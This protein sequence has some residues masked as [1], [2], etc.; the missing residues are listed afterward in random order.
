VFSRQCDS[1]VEVHNKCLTFKKQASM[2]LGLSMSVCNER[3]LRTRD[4]ELGIVNVLSYLCFK[5]FSIVY[6]L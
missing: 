2:S 5:K 4:I 3:K 6:E 1:V